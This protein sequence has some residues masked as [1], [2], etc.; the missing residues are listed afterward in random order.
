MSKKKLLSFALCLC[1]LLSCLFFTDNMTTATG[2][3]SGVYESQE[4]VT[5]PESDFTYRKTPVTNPTRA[6]I[7]KYNGK[8]TKVI[9]PETLEGLPVSSITA[10]A[11]SESETLTYVKLP[12]TLIAISGAAFSMCSSLESFDIDSSNPDFTVVDGVLYRKDA[13]EFIQRYGQSYWSDG[14]DCNYRSECPLSLCNG[15]QPNGVSIF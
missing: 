13:S 1:V 12:S 6:V 7:T 8:E 2:G 10:N 4:P 3:I 15:R 14:C 5:P 9:I 11:F